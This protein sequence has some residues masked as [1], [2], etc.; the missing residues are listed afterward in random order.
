MCNYD[1]GAAFYQAGQ[2]VANPQLGLGVFQTP[3][4]I[5]ASVVRTA[6]A[7]GYRHIDTA[8]VYVNELG[9]GEGL[10]A[11]EIARSEVFVTTKLWN[12]ALRC[13]LLT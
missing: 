12:G 4:D 7:T 11:A 3:P 10:R 8:A 1:G 2:C 13:N 5:T 6:L 9:V